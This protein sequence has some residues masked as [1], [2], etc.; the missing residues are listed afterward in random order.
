MSKTCL[1][2]SK[3]CRWLVFENTSTVDAT[4]QLIAQAVKEGKLGSSAKVLSSCG[5]AV[6][7]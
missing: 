7:H 2:V 4:W 5:G 6:D 3:C 1:A